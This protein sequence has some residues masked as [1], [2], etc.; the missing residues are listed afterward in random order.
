MVELQ[1]YW[2]SPKYQQQMIMEMEKVFLMLFKCICFSVQVF[3]LTLFQQDS[4]F[5]IMKGAKVGAR[6]GQDEKTEGQAKPGT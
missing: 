3:S 1:A 6:K 2:L 4:R 5:W